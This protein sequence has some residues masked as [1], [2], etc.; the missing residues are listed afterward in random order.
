MLF[1]TNAFAHPGHD[2]AHWLSEPIHVLT[3][4]AIVGIALVGVYMTAKNKLTK[5]M[6][7]ED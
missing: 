7:K 5:T 4:F 1:S 2:H 6:N 3:V